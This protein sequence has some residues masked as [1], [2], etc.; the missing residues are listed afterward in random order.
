L[1]RIGPGKKIGSSSNNNQKIIHH[2]ARMP[3]HG[4]FKSH[5]GFKGEGIVVVSEEEGG[6]GF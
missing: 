4:F 6:F 5:G 1:H 2:V 3:G